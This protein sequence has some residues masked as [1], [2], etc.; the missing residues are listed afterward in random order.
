MANKIKDKKGRFSNEETVTKDH[1]LEIIRM[2]KQEAEDARRTRDLL[3]DRNWAAYQSKQDWTHKNHDQS[4]EFNPRTSMAVESVTATIKKALVGQGNYFSMDLVDESLM[5]SN[6]ARDLLKFHL[7]DEKTDFVGAVE[8]GVKIALLSSVMTFKTRHIV[9]DDVFILKI[10][11][12]RPEKT[13]PDPSGRE[14]YFIHEVVLDLHTVVQRAKK[15]IYDKEEVAKIQTDFVE[16]DRLTREAKQRNDRPPESNFRK[17]VTLHEVWGTLVDESGEI[18]RGDIVATMANKQYLI[19]KPAKNPRFHGKWPFVR[20]PIV[21]IPGS[22]WHKALYDDAVRINLSLNELENL[23]LDGALAAAHDVKIL[24]PD[25]LKNPEQAS[26]GVPPG[27]TLLAN[28]DVT[29]LKDVMTTV[30]TGQVPNDSLQMYNLSL[31]NFDVASLRSDIDLGSLPEKQVKATEIV[32]KKQAS[33]QQLDGFA[34]TVEKA[35]A[36]TLRLAWAEIMQFRTNYLEL[37]HIIGEKAAFGLSLMPAEERYDTFAK[38]TAF[39][40]DGISSLIT[41]GQNFQK[42]MVVTDAVMKSP[43]LVQAFA[44]EYSPKKIIDELFKGVD[45]DPATIKLDKNETGIQPEEIEAL[46]GGQKTGADASQAG[47]R[48]PVP[49]DRF[50]AGKQK[51]TLQ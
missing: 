31:R 36:S 6:Q 4:K 43:I 16:Q 30:A 27:T 41:S 23:M 17:R 14:L 38:K 13:F 29:D 15:G 2:Y 10:D 18:V 24:K 49:N 21:R 40:V 50:P 48:N 9:E 12:E 35:I 5:T 1:I 45:L 3:N 8:M 7:E 11:S 44:Q 33:S 19:R 34:R 42:L 25:S 28:E 26:G 39:K 22:V 46:S 32:Q 51:E 37:E 47:G 20:T